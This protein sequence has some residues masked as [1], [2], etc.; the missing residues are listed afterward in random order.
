VFTQ[1]VR[2]HVTKK[3]VSVFVRF[4]APL[5]PNYTDAEKWGI[6]QNITWCQENESY[7]YFYRKEMLYSN[8]QS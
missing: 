7:M 1:Q 6:L 8:D 5:Q 2:R 4:R 3:V